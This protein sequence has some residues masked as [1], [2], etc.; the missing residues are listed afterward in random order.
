M[1]LRYSLPS[2]LVVV[3]VVW[4]ALGLPLRPSET[5]AYPLRSGTPRVMGIS[6]LVDAALNASLW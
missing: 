2:L 1:P 6:Q 5:L 3:G 4:C